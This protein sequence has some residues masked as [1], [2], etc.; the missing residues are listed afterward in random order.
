MEDQ[1]SGYLLSIPGPHMGNSADKLQG[2]LERCTGSGPQLLT[3]KGL[4]P[5]F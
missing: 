4:N 5:G 3:V 2:S 1:S